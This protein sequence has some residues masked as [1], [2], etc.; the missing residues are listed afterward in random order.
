MEVVPQIPVAVA[1]AA[2]VIVAS[3][4]IACR[5]GAKGKVA[6]CR[7]AR[8]HDNVTGRPAKQLSG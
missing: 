4:V 5:S 8:A 6:P 3:V 1:V 7:P 2:I